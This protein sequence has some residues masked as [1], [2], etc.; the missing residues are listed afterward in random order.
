MHQANNQNI[1][2]LKAFRYKEHLVQKCEQNVKDV[3]QNTPFFCSFIKIIQIKFYPFRTFLFSFSDF[4]KSKV[5][6]I[7]VKRF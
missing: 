2:L 6:Y 5:F 1:E 4:L 3:S 7:Y